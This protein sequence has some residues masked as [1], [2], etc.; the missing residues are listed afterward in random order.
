M[1]RCRGGHYILFRIDGLHH[2][3]YQTVAELLA[4]QP[5]MLLT[6]EL[7]ERARRR[8]GEL[9]DRAATRL[10]VRPEADGFATVDVVVVELASVPAGAVAWAGTAA[11]AA[12]NREIATAL[13]GANGQG[14]VWS[15]SWRWWTNRPGVTVGFAAPRVAGLPGVWRFEGAWQSDT[16]RTSTSSQTV[17][18]RTHGG[19]AVSD[20]LSGS[21]RYQI[22][23]GVDSWSGGR[24]A[25]SIGAALERVAFRDRLSLSIDT[26][27]WAP[28]NGGI[29]FRSIGAHAIARSSTE[30][31]GWV[32]RATA[33][34]ERVSDAAPFALWPGAGEGQVR[35]TLLRAH[36]LLSDG[37]VDVG[38]SSAFGRTL[39]SA[40]RSCSDGWSGRRSCVWASRDLSTSR[41]RRDRRTSGHAG[42]RRCGRGSSHQDSRNARGLRADVAH[43]LRDGANALTVGWQS[44]SAFR[45]GVTPA[46]LTYA[47]DNESTPAWHFGYGGRGGGDRRPR[48]ARGPIEW[49]AY[50]GDAGGSKYSPADQITRANVAT[51]T[52][53][54][55]YRTGDYGVG[56]TQARDETTPISSMASS[57]SRRRSAACARSTARPAGSAGPSTPSSISPATTATLRTAA[58]RPGS[59]RRRRAP[60]RRRIFVTPVDARLIALD[61]R[62]GVPCAGSANGDKSISIAGSPM[63]PPTTASTPSPRL[64]R[65]STVLAVVGSSVSDGSRAATPNGVVRAFDARTGALKWSWDPVAREPRRRA[66]TRGAER[67]RTRPAPP[68]PGRSS[69]RSARDLDSFRLAAPA[70]I[71]TAAN[72]SARTS[73]PTRWSRSARRR[74]NWSGIFRPCITT[75]GTTTSRLSRYC[76]RFA[77]TAARSWRWRSRPRWDSCSF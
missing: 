7:F 55:T 52:P 27:Q 76:S 30:T 25:V 23:T 62:T 47:S 17:E 5:N 49:T 32:M 69:A 15:A 51:L 66:T 13:P 56:R 10:A 57:S 2:T 60:C 29:A 54:W 36:P 19:L 12:T 42:P 53:A 43:G 73:S 59:I 75:C 70:R 58:Y 50:A 71:S 1:S 64:R 6:A 61:A 37:V 31:R 46:V 63:R 3:R 38:G 11:R 18:S 14:D 44:K 72:V 65:S 39:T 33:G 40:A 9:P 21:V 48:A 41:A 34:F 4:I 28:L 16:Y 26:A 35:G 67:R 22:S 74:D 20:W 68:T 77:G 8:L 45:I 24:K